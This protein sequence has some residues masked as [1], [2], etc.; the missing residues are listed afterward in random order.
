[1][2]SELLAKDEQ[3]QGDLRVTS[4]VR[5]AFAAIGDSSAGIADVPLCVDGRIR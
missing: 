3:D 2:E 5:A 1:M 4:L